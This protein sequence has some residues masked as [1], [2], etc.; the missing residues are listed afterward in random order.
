MGSSSTSERT[1]PF[2]CPFKEVQS[3]SLSA[4]PS[5]RMT[6]EHR[7]SSR[8]RICLTTS[9][10]MRRSPLLAVT[11]GS[12]IIWWGRYFSSASTT[13]ASVSV[14]LIMP[15][16]TVSGCTSL[17]IASICPLTISA[18]RSWKAWIPSV[19][20]TVIEVTADTAYPPSA[21]IVLMSACTPDPPVLSEPVMVR[22]V[23]N[24][25]R[26]SFPIS[27]TPTGCRKRHPR[28]RSAGKHDAK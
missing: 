2:P 14:V 12:Y 26:L 6:I 24:S 27:L 15:T 23:F 8:C 16:F 9:S 4:S 28:S 19:F 25:L 1:L 5:R 7:G 21:A 3:K 13:T 11:I 22:I 18:G 17:M 10:V 20:C